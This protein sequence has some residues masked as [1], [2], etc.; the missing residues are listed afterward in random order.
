MSNRVGIVLEG[1]AMRSLFSAGVVDFLMDKG[2][3][4]PNM[5]AVSAGA[6]A[7]MNYASGQR[8]RCLE[9][10]VGTLEEYPYMGPKTFFTKGTFFDMDYL[11]DVVPKQKFPFDFEMFR[12]FAGRFITSTVDLTTGEANYHEHFESEEELFSICRAANS[13]PFLAKVASVNG[14]PSLDGGMADAI[15]IER[16]L[17]E[18]WDK[19]VVVLTRDSA[20]R[21]AEKSIPYMTL[22]RLVYRKYPKFIKL[23]EGR[24][25]R[26]NDSIDKVEQLEKEGRVFLIRPTEL[27][28]SNSESNVP[29]LR[30]YY[31]HGYDSVA[32]RY[33]ELLEFLGE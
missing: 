5:L 12:R 18:D 2:I 14:V 22:L 17:Q 26:Y 8:G 23:V 24:A 7:G 4:I 9:S 3:H 15:P 33:E 11:F 32:A 6:Y 16:A 13:M 30:A 31:Q 10:M 25:K 29:K 28:I 21:K 20:Y 1:G 19:M 27:T